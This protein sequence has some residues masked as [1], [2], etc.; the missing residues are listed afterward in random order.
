[1]A[2]E[3]AVLQLRTD[4]TGSS[5]SVCSRSSQHHPDHEHRINQGSTNLGLIARKLG[6]DPRQI[7]KRGERVNEVI[8]WHNL[9]EAK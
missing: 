2:R 6:M 5:R 7:E 9:V 8:V 4:Q 1:M 3:V